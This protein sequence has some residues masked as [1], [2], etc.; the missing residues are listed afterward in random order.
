MALWSQIRG[1]SGHALHASWGKQLASV[2]L[3]LGAV[4]AAFYRPWASLTLIALVA[5]MWLLPPK[6]GQGLG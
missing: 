2:L 4:P 3:Y 1:R 5:V 6:R